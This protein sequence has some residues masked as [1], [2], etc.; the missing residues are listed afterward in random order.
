MISCFI[1]C[2]WLPVEEE[3]N[4]QVCWDVVSTGGGARE[5]WSKV[6][7]TWDEHLV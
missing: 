2:P 5:E 7:K 6:D 1:L 3:A 4:A